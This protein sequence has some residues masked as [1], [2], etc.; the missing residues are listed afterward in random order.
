LK[1]DNSFFV[2][3][4]AVKEEVASGDEEEENND[5]APMQLTPDQ[6]TVLV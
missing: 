3:G 1:E 2:Q 4:V 6:V 5:S